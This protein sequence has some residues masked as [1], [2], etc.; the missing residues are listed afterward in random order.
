V[1]R[2]LFLALALL[3][4][5]GAAAA[6]WVW[7]RRRRPRLRRRRRVPPRPR[8]PVVLVH[9]LFGFD[10]IGVGASRQVYFRG[11]GDALA[12]D[13]HG[14]HVARMP[15]ARS[16]AER[17]Q[18]LARC[19]RSIDAKRV[20]LVAHSM[21]GL[22]ARY[23]ITRLGLRPSVA[24]LLTIGTPHRGSPLADLSAELAAKLGVA[25][26]LAAGGLSLG[27]LGDLTTESLAVF[28]GRVPDCRGVAYLSVVG[29]VRRKRRT[30]PLLLPSYLWM[31][32][33]WGEND[34]IVPS[35]SQRWGKVVAEIEADHWAQIGWSSHFDAPR[36]YVRL[37]R[38]LRALGF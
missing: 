33:Q 7:L 17:A 15:A 10:E 13:G 8:Y 30:N 36:F 6:L 31:R 21:G 3:L 4:L 18:E 16:I 23:A 11:I 25:R 2:A 37:L 9:G 34:G 26:A 14:I 28:N 5:G 38:E 19:V 29:A 1:N 20:N 32:R 27:A 35:S 12:K 24:T 22:D